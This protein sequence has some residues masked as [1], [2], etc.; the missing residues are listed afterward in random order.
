MLPPSQCNQWQHGEASL[1]TTKEW[2]ELPWPIY[3]IGLKTIGI[4]A[5]FTNFT[6]VDVTDF[7]HFASF[8]HTVF[9]ILGL[10][11]PKVRQRMLITP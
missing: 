5:N 4:V 7:A 3:G 11:T 9:A 10:E 1:P 2:V 8:T 6:Y